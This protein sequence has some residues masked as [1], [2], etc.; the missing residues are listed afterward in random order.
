MVSFFGRLAARQN[1]VIVLL[2]LWAIM[3]IAAVRQPK[4]S[5]VNL[6]ILPKDISD[7]KLD[8]L[9]LQDFERALGV[10]CDYCHVEDK[11][12]KKLDY[13]SDARPEKETARDMM[14]MTLELNK[15]YFKVNSPALGDST[16]VVTC[17]TCH[18]ENPV[19]KGRVQ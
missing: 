16:L 19:P 1:R 17:Y 11:T 15:T 9:M 14:R 5:H 18:R 10:N 13:A 3:G 12:T 7:Q 8:K 4:D 6:K 2:V